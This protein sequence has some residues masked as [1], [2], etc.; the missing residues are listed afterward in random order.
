MCLSFARS[1]SF[2]SEYEEDTPSTGGYFSPTADLGK[3]FEYLIRKCIAEKMAKSREEGEKQTECDNSAT[4][5]ASCETAI[6]STA[7][8]LIDAESS[9]SGH[10]G[11]DKSMV[12]EAQ[13]SM[14][15]V[16]QQTCLKCNHIQ[17]NLDKPC[18]NSPVHTQTPPA[19]AREEQPAEVTPNAPGRPEENT[20]EPGNE[21]AKETIGNTSDNKD[22]GLFCE[23]DFP[24]LSKGT[25]H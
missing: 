2:D 18:D 24:P 5:A 6:D 17:N 19:M 21:E 15:T 4:F 14:E 8:E 1:I 25:C 20:G 16:A 7:V 13:S 10:P 22:T 9:N 11:S 3:D 23:F 12:Q